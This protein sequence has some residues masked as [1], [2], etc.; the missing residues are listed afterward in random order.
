[1]EKSCECAAGNQRGRGATRA[2]SVRLRVIA[3]L[4]CLCAASAQAQTGPFGHLHSPPEVVTSRSE[5]GI[6]FSLDPTEYTIRLPEGFQDRDNAE[7]QGVA[8]RYVPG[9]SFHCRR[10]TA[11][12]QELGFSSGMY[13]EIV[14]PRMEDDPTA[15]LA[16]VLVDLRYWYYE[17]TGQGVREVALE[18]SID[19]GP[20]SA[21]ALLIHRTDYSAPRPQ[22]HAYL[23]ERAVLE[24]VAAGRSWTLEARGEE[25]AFTMQ[26]AP[27]PE[28][29]RAAAQGL[30]EIC[31]P[32]G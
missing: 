27:G 22:L 24:N 7:E 3:T 31:A 8:P 19:G 10:S 23:P 5:E 18:I 30:L 14:I 15:A 11:R 16:V 25:A 20:T 26:F 9:L 13:V 12:S 4:A 29:V 28:P 17:L 1:M 21:T 2:F 6:W 32:V